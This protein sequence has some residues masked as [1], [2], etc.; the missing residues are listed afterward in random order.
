MTPRTRLILASVA[1]AVLWTL[2]AF[3]LPS[4]SICGRISRGQA[5][6][7]RRTTSTGR[8]LPPDHLFKVFLSFFFSATAGG[9]GGRQPIL[10]QVHRQRVQ[11][12]AAKHIAH[13]EQHT[14]ERRVHAAVVQ[15]ID[16][17]AME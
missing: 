13:R 1:F 17:A 16:D 12:G 3:S 14:A 10:V 2:A 7:R 4:I 8:W 5:A 15:G 11:A 9:R 6:K